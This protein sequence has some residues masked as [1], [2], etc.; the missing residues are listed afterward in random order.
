MPFRPVLLMLMIFAACAVAPGAWADSPAP[1]KT[2]ILSGR[3]SD[4]EGWPIQGA[5]IFAGS[6][7]QPVAM[8]DADGRYTI[9]LFVGSFSGLVQAPYHDVFRASRK[10]WDFSASSGGPAV[11]IEARVIS[12]SDGVARLQARS[13]DKA[14]A[15]A[16][17]EA[18]ARSGDKPAEV[19]LHFVGRRGPESR[20]GGIVLSEQSA[21]PIETGDAPPEMG[22]PPFGGRHVGAAGAQTAAPPAPAAGAGAKASPDRTPARG[23]SA[24]PAPAASSGATARPSTA[25][26]PEARRKPWRLFPSADELLEEH[27]AARAAE[28]AASTAESENAPA[29]E[30]TTYRI[31]TVV[32]SRPIS[33]TSTRAPAGVDSVA[34]GPG[35]T[36]PPTRP[37]VSAPVQSPPAPTVRDSRSAAQAPASRT[38]APAKSQPPA[39]RTPPPTVGEYPA[40][41]TPASAS[42]QTPATRTP[43]PTVGQYPISRTPVPAV[44]QTPAARAPA[45]SGGSPG[46]QS[47]RSSIAVTAAPQTTRGRAYE[48]DSSAGVIRVWGGRTVPSDPAAARAGAVCECTVK[49]T[50]EVRRSQMLRD[51]VPVLVQI[52]GLPAFR[53]TVELFEGSSR[54]FEIAGVPCGRRRIEIES[55]GRRRFALASAL[56]LG[57]F[58]CQNGRYR[59]IHVVL[60]P[61]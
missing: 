27:R 44:T 49:G 47:G 46:I 28:N 5:S 43:P 61:R 39:S 7:A 41:R 37:V 60:I 35:A 45:K 11:A 18:L 50:I 26:A 21:H 40:L 55:F 3:V 17:A 8:T 58:E 15:T 1:A 42:A 54:S 38:S 22:L 51:R 2:L 33:A 56:P 25:R 30:D 4:A 48:S 9:A 36:A 59:Q 13:N 53:D 14:V 24:T 52:A 6:R 29:P 12:G 31:R 34:R 10:G 57:E 23:P 19:S 16:V 20:P 32:P